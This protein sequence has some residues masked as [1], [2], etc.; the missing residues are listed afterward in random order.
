MTPQ[1]KTRPPAA[2]VEVGT[3]DTALNIEQRLLLVMAD[4]GYLKRDAVAPKE[5]GGF[6]FIT[7]DAV[8]AALRPIFIKHGVLAVPTVINHDRE[9]NQTT[10]VIEVA[11]INVDNP[12]DRCVVRSVGY[13]IDKQDKGPGKAM[14]YAVKYALLKTFSLETGDDVE[15]ASIDRDAPARGP[16]PA[17]NG[18]AHHTPGRAPLA[19]FW[20]VAR[21]QKVPEEVIRKWFTRNLGVESTK[22]ATDEQLAEATLWAQNI[23]G[24]QRK[25]GEAAQVLDLGPRELVEEAGRMFGTDGLGELTL[26]EWDQFIGW[27]EA[28]ANSTLDESIVE[29]S[30]NDDDLPF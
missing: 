14:S 19:R 7:H 5:I 17:S 24:R 18:D 16:A 30:G 25:L 1:A 3:H 23:Q 4:I 12:D 10:L 27:A 21:G 26:T 9:G 29:A 20:T 22:E 13:G 8:T 2:P 15:A 6:S 28:K 11:F